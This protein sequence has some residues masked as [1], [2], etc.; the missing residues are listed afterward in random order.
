MNNVNSNRIITDS[1]HVDLNK[2]IPDHLE[3]I[4]DSAENWALNQLLSWDRDS[5]DVANPVD[6]KTQL[7]V[8]IDGT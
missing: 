8:C 7:D 3:T 4:N 1:N 2:S 6:N 5:T